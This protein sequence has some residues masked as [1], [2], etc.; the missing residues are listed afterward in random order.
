MG[1]WVK[2]VDCLGF[3]LSGVYAATNKENTQNIILK[4][5]AVDTNNCLYK[6]LI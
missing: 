5:K 3:S 1:K 4:N 2:P 6:P